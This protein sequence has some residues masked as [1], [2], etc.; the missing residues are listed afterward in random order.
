MK[1]LIKDALDAAIIQ[2]ESRI[3]TTKKKYHYIS[4]MDI[5]PLKV[6]EFMKDNNI[7]D[8]AEFDGRANGYDAWDD[9]GLSWTTDVPMTA[10]DTLTAKKK[11]FNN[12]AFKFVYDKLTSNGYKRVGYN[13]G[14]LKEFDDTTAFDMYMD[15]DFDRLV[16][17]YSLP[18][19]KV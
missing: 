8:D 5:S 19:V 13:T 3:P 11:R 18:F 17:Y 15:N 6:T 1:N 14:L 12:A 10:N 4:V 2:V 16:R 9:F 7:P